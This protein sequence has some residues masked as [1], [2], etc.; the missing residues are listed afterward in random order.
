LVGLE[1]ASGVG[2]TRKQVFEIVYWKQIMNR[3]HMHLKKRL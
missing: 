1:N 3:E 2:E